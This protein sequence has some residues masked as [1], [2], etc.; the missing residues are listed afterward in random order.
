MRSIPVFLCIFLLYLGGFL[1]HSLYLGKTVYGDG[2]FYFSWL[3]G[4]LVRHSINFTP[5]YAHFGVSQPLTSAGLPGNKYSVGPA[6]FWAPGYIPM[7]SLL[8]GSGYGLPYQIMIGGVSVLSALFGLVLLYRLL[9]RYVS[10]RAAKLGILGIAFATNLLYYGALDP[11]NSHALSFFAVCLFLSFL[12]AERKQWFLIGISLGLVALIRP[13]D[14]V[15][16]LVALPY[17]R[18]NAWVRFLGGALTGFLPEL[19]AWLALYGS[20]VSPYLGRG[21]GFTFLHPHI[22]EVLFA[23][24]YGLFFFSPILLVG[25]AGLWRHRERYVYLLVPAAAV[26][27]I[28]SWSTWWQGASVGSRMMIGTLPLFAIGLGI[29]FEQLLKRMSTRILVLVLLAP[30][31]V[32]NVLLTASY[33]ALH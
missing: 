26:Y 18:P 30:L 2:I 32:L 24:W 28:A 31:S 17:L 33:L 6:M 27:L 20:F 29:S 21:E 3:H 4:V 11:V 13:Q 22:I 10:D 7:L 25:A 9:L 8:G 19:L 14:A 12:A 16:G 23:P 1:A 5:E 15:V